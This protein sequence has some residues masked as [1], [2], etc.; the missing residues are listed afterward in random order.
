[1]QIW[2]SDPPLASSIKYLAVDL[3]GRSQLAL[4]RLISH[5]LNKIKIKQNLFPQAKAT[6]HGV[7]RSKWS[8]FRTERPR[9]PECRR[10]P[11]RAATTPAN[12]RPAPGQQRPRAGWVGWSSKSPD[13]RGAEVALPS[14]NWLCYQDSCC[15]SRQ[16]LCSANF[17]M[18]IVKKNWSRGLCCCACAAAIFS[19]RSQNER[20]IY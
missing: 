13:L 6:R 17:K 12:Q 20:W 4:L 5:L 15:D 18:L 7:S 9:R 16:I 8:G 1:M 14:C 10:W 3:S 19:T 2:E 11:L